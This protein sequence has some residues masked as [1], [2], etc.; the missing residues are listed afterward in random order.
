MTQNEIVFFGGKSLNPG[1]FISKHAGSLIR[2]SLRKLVNK[3]AEPILFGMLVQKMGSGV[4]V[5]DTEN[6]PICG[7]VL[8]D[9]FLSDYFES[10]DGAQVVL[11]YSQNTT[12]P[13]YVRN[14]EDVQ[15]L[16]DNTFDVTQPFDQVYVRF[17]NGIQGSI[18]NVDGDDVT[19]VPGL[20]WIGNTGAIQPLEFSDSGFNAGFN[21]TLEI[22][23]TSPLNL[24]IVSNPDTD[25]AIHLSENP[26]DDV[27]ITITSNDPAVVQVDGGTSKT[28]VFSP[29]NYTTD[30][31]TN[32]SIT[33]GQN[34]DGTTTIS[35]TVSSVNSDWNNVIQPDY[36]VNVNVTPLTYVESLPIQ[37]DEQ[38][39]TPLQISLSQAPTEDVVISAISSDTD[40]LTL[41]GTP[42]TFTSENFSTPQT[43]TLNS[44]DIT[45]NENVDISFNVSSSDPNWDGVVV[46]DVPVEILNSI[47]DNWE[48]Q[49]SY[50]PTPVPGTPSAGNPL[51]RL[52]D[53]IS[54]PD[55]N[56]I[57][58]WEISGD[59]NPVCSI[60]PQW[61]IYAENLTTLARLGETI[62]DTCHSLENFSTVTINNV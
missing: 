7:I 37:F 1:T 55:S 29:E 46:P 14:Y 21:G 53:I 20:R 6:A 24:D 38:D 59:T 30:Q 50:D 8:I 54:V 9:E 26:F 35:I 19:P 28:L 62:V 15:P 22:E 43:L 23:L 58:R 51:P 10:T 32:V 42:L 3:G 61:R 5:P 33:P 2:G 39:S 52:T 25:L 12:V 31:V 13:I 48:V 57:G 49:I 27:T 34:A 40:V 41:S 36:D 45:M 44:Q 11:G 56:W 4:S 47:P 17:Q 18:T 16:L 60:V